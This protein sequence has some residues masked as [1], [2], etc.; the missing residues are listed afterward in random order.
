M[1][2]IIRV[3]CLCSLLFLLVACGEE[4]PQATLIIPDTDTDVV[5]EAEPTTEI[6]STETPTPE[7]T[8]TDLPPTETAT[9]VPTETPTPEPSPTPTETPLPT[10]TPTAT[11]EPIVLLSQEEIDAAERSRLT[12]ELITDPDVLGRRPIICKISNAPPEHT[13]PQAGIG[14]A[15]MVFEHIAEGATRFSALFY[16]KAPEYV[17]P[18][19]S[20]RLI[21]TYLVPM[22]DTALC[23]SGASVGVSERLETSNFR[24]RLMRSYYEGYAR[25][26][27]GDDV[28][29]EHT[30]V[31][32]LLPFW[33]WME[34]WEHNRVP[35]S[36]TQMTFTEMPP[37]GGISAETARVQY[38]DWTVVEWDWDTERNR[39][40]RTADDVVAT[41]VTTDEVI[42]AA[43][44][45]ILYASHFFDETICDWQL[46]EV[47]ERTSD[48]L[49]GGLYPDL[50][51]DGDFILL[52]DGQQFIGRWEGDG[53]NMLVFNDADG[54]PLPFQIGNTWFQI[55][56][57]SYYET[58]LITIE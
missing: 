17:G 34:E 36:E 3:V 5:A 41:D 22:Y 28:P 45:V 24:S 25:L 7:P 29:F 30:M 51:D 31:A 39:W 43:N 18:I 1:I 58:D 37:E 6:V 4:E 23:F 52:R 55:V 8:A 40:V 27:R 50:A 48:C 19:R 10:A 56:P 32:D 33:D 16:S 26:D 20:A 53:K 46:E 12:G 54:E 57:Y 21:D 35:E 11:P 44:V 15:D 14:S 47:P 38:E 49:I 13:R 42:T 9:S 2:Q